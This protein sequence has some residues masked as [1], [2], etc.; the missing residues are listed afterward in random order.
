MKEL[1][2]T[3]RDNKRAAFIYKTAKGFEI[4]LTEGDKYVRTGEAYDHSESWAEDVA[5]NW[6][7]K[8]IRS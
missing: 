2:Q 4:D 5:H 1:I 3:V 8:I 6:T 7:D